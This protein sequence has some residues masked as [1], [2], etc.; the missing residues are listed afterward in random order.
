MNIEDRDTL[1]G[2]V[3]F[4]GS[5]DKYLEV[6]KLVS[7]KYIT[8]NILSFNRLIFMFLMNASLNDKYWS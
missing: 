1:G 3:N 5:Q 2:L 4:K 6:A 8:K 7:I